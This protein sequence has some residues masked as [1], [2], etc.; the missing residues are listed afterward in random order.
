MAENKRGKYRVAIG[1]S[2]SESSMHAIQEAVQLAKQMPNAD[3]HFVHVLEAPADL[4]DAYLI[5]RLSERLGRTMIRLETYVRDALFVFCGQEAWGCDVAFHV[6]IGPAAREIHQ[7][8][9]D[10]DAEMIIVG[11]EHT[12]G[13][14][15]L[16]GSLTTR[17]LVKT[18]HVP[19]V[20]AHQKDFKGLPRTQLPD[21]PHAGNELSRSGLTS[22]TYVD[23]GAHRDSH[24][25]GLI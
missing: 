19:V 25:S 1:V 7:V 10:I 6:R 18:A 8:A 4:H 12:R 15:R 13:L 17:G 3:L 9:V 23:F 21:P 24:I 11:A 22:Y 5:D 14:R 16:L 20:V 2:F